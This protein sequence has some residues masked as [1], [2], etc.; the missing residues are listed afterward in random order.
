[1][2]QDK[3]LLLGAENVPEIIDDAN[4]IETSKCSVVK[5]VLWQ[6]SLDR[7]TTALKNLQALI[8]KNGFENNQLKGE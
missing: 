1:M 5:N 2:S 6:M 8:L 4:D 7:K 3:D